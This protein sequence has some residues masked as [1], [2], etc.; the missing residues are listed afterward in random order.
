[1]ELEFS[2][3]NNTVVTLNGEV[4][5]G[6]CGASVTRQTTVEK[7]E[8]YLTDIPVAVIERVRY[9]ISL[10]LERGAEA[11]ECG[12]PESIGFCR[13]GGEGV[14]FENCVLK[15]VKTDYSASGAAVHKVSV[16][17]YQRRY[18]YE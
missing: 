13:V 18:S 10:T 2:I 14:I 12:R 4:L 6:V 16:I 11:F 8:T 15:S 17:A 7:I 3:D 5:G 1:M 9:E